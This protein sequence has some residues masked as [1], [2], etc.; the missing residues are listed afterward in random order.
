MREQLIINLYNLLS[1]LNKKQ[2]YNYLKSPINK[3]FNC[4]IYFF[5]E[6]DNMINDTQSRI[7]YIGITK[8]NKNN[9]LEKHQKGGT[10]SSSFRKHVK[11]ALLVKHNVNFRVEMISEYIHNLPFLFIPIKNEKNISEIENH[12][13]QIISNAN[14]KTIHKPQDTWLGFYIDDDLKNSHIW[15]VQQV[16]NY[17][18]SKNDYDSTLNL[19][20]EYINLI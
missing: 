9:R 5:F 17:D 12:C 10:S 2:Q 3:N 20:M 6:P 19:L 13:I 16:L 14:Q 11:E 18:E 1:N 4:G 15:N 8:N 7:S